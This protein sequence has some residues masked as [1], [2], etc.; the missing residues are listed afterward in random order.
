[1]TFD[2]SFALKL[3]TPSITSCPYSL[4]VDQRVGFASA[5]VVRTH[6]AGGTFVRCAKGGREGCTAY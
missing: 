2:S 5:A 3:L 1:M 4:L 6:C